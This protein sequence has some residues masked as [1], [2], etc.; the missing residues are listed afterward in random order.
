MLDLI[1]RTNGD[2]LGMLL[3]IGLIVYFIYLEKREWYELILLFGCIVGLIVDTRTTIK[4][5]KK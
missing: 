2:V 3:F 4:K 5:W 1:K